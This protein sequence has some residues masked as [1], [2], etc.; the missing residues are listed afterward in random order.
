MSR[1]V[2]CGARTMNLERVSVMGILNVTPDSFSDGGAYA[3]PEAAIARGLEMVEHGADILDL[4]GESTR[5]GAEPVDDEEEW[6]RVGPVLTGLRRQTS[7]FLSIDTTKEIVARRALD[8]GADL[9]NDVS[10]GM[11]DCRILDLVAERKAGLIL[12]H[13][14][15]TPQ[16]M[17]DLTHYDDLIG[18][19]RAELL[20]RV[21]GALD[22]GVSAEQIIID[23]GIGFAKDAAGSC[24]LI[25][26][27]KDFVETG[28]PVM[29]G[30]SRK[31]F[32][33]AILNQPNPRERLWGTAAAVALCV[34]FGAR[35]LRVH[36]VREMVQ[37]VR[38]CEAICWTDT[39]S[40]HGEAP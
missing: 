15:G 38:T 2:R 37:V 26:R 25:A 30:P 16:T 11:R 3:D 17:R 6:H 32:I 12:M 13:M 36:D 34:A 7:V 9:V 19:V 21:D 1:H 8:A 20:A 27:L 4:G 22:H 24:R 35:L 10:G 18:T 14:R 40:L 33:G 29:V 23:P 31:S 28:Y 5:P 39:D